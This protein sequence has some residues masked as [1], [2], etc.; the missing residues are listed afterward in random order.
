MISHK[1]IMLTI[2]LLHR[3]HLDLWG[4]YNLASMRDNSYFVVIIDD[5]IRKMWTYS[6]I[7]KKM[8]FS[9]FKMWKKGVETETRLKFSNLQIDYRGK[10]IS[11]ALKK[12]CKKE[13]VVI[14][15]TLPYIHEQNSIAKWS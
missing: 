5:N 7:S 6:I 11:L 9:V 13:K 12:F 4:P 2:R 3:A 10:Y 8:F 15:F 14:E 1:P